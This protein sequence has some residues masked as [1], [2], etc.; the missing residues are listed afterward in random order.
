MRDKFYEILIRREDEYEKIFHSLSTFEKKKILYFFND[1][2]LSFLYD[3]LVT[4]KILNKEEFW[5]FL[6]KK[7]T[8]KISF[9]NTLQL[10]QLS[11]NK[12]IIDY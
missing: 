2:F 11:S 8:S 1:E 3:E 7:Y 12:K 5:I 9:L 10:I 6:K 4:K